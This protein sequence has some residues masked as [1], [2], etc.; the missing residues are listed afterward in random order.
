MDR[1]AWQ[2]IVHEVARVGCDSA[3]KQQVGDS[4]C[5]TAETNAPL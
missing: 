3:T 1:G 5:C 4:H 2:A